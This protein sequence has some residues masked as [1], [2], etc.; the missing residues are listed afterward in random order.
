MEDII[1]TIRVEDLRRIFQQHGKIHTKQA[2]ERFYADVH[3][4]ALV[5]MEDGQQ[6]PDLSEG[7]R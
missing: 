5:R 3:A 2:W 4:V 6:N 7:T 1:I